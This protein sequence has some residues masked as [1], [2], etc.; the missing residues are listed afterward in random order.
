MLEA[1]N[2]HFVGVDYDARIKV[3]RVGGHLYK[4]CARLTAA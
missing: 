2:I 3:G 1:C 4:A